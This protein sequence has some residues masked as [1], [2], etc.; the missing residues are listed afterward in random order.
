MDAFL[1]FSILLAVVAGLG[2]VV[3]PC[4]LPFIPVI[5]TYYLG[6]KRSTLGGIVGGAFVV[7]GLV[8]FAVPFGLIITALDFWATPPS[9]TP[10]FEG[11]AG[12][13]LLVFGL[14]TVLDIHI[15]IFSP[16]LASPEGKGYRTLYALGLLY[17]MASIGCTIWPFM[18]VVFVASFSPLFGLVVYTTYVATIAAPVLIMAFF[19]AEARELLVGKIARYERWIRMAGGIA[20]LGAGLYLIQYGI[21]PLLSAGETG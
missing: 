9:V 18:G 19:A 3:S 1:S 11:I 5:L 7:G 20:L 21:E 15:P 16:T 14:L 4:G 12:A 17:G 8:T 6:D 13:L 2:T 10:W